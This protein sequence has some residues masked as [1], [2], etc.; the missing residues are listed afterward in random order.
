MRVPHHRHHVSTSHKLPQGYIQCLP[1]G[2]RVTRDR[3]AFVRFSYKKGTEQ[4]FGTRHPVLGTPRK[5]SIALGVVMHY[6]RERNVAVTRLAA[7]CSDIPLAPTEDDISEYQD[8]I[9]LFE[10][11]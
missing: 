6:Q 5:N 9:E 2:S 3:T 4:P 11:A 7:F 8:I 10:D 1:V